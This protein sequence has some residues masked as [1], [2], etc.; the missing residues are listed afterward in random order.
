MQKRLSAKLST[1]K[2]ATRSWGGGPIERAEV[3]AGEGRDQPRELWKWAVLAGLIVLL[4]EW[5]I[6]NR[7]VYV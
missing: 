2:T 5:Y 3:Q 1:V 6:Y 4:L 7:R